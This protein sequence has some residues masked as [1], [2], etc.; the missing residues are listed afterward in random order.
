[1]ALQK[2]ADYIQSRQEGKVEDTNPDDPLTPSTHLNKRWRYIER[3]P[4]F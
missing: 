1:V 3:F 4:R 2:Q